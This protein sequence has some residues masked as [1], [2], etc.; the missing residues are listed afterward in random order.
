MK[1]A[2]V[3][4]IRDYPWGA[5]G[6]CVAGLVSSLLDAGHSV[7]WVVAPIDRTHPQVA[8]LGHRGAIV[9]LLPQPPGTYVRL[10]GMRRAI[11]RTLGLRPALSGIV[12]GFAPDHLFFNQGGTWSALEEEFR[13]CWDG[14]E[15]RFSLV[16]HLNQP[17]PAF[18]PDRMQAARK[19]MK[20]AARVFFNSE[21]TRALAE[22][23]IAEEIA[24]AA[25]FQLP[26]RFEFDAPLPWPHNEVPRIAMVSRLDAH[27]KGIDIALQALALLKK[28]GIKVRFGIFGSGPDE[29]YLKGLA[30]Y[31]GLSSCVTFHGHTDDLPRVWRSEEL[32]LL[33]SRFE[34]LAVS[35]IEAM[36]FGRPVIRTPFGGALEWMRDGENGYVCRAAEAEVV[37]E[38]LRKALS[39][40]H[41]WE[42]MGL[43]AHE[44]V[45]HSLDRTP[46]NAFLRALPVQAVD[47]RK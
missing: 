22:S 18:S 6:D 8:R 29:H 35:M 28:E 5:P 1:V 32:L 4:T 27:H 11:R 47:E 17:Q 46:A 20:G 31:L 9:E 33:P 37:A 7:L 24:N 19:M 44:L 41:R 10:A 30:D 15:G 13:E 23:Q 16:C 39:E 25:F 42:G 43:K 38:T 34:G 26:V 36:G 3:P 21:W 40:R 14:L 12:K 45:V 2:V